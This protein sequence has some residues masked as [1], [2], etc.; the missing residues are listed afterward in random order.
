MDQQPNEISMQLQVW[1]GSDNSS[2]LLFSQRQHP[3]T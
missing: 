2:V 3:V 1:Q